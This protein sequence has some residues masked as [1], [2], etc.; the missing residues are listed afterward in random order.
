M[1][2]NYDFANLT[3]R[4]F[5]SLPEVGNKWIVPADTTL[6]INLSDNVIENVQKAIEA[7]GIRYYHLP[8]EERP[9]MSI[10]PLLQAVRLLK[11]QDALGGHMIVHCLFGNNRSRTV[12]D[13]FY[14]VKMGVHRPPMD[15]DDVNRLIF[16]CEQGYL[17]SL[18]EMEG[19]LLNL[20]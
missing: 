13:A 15:E 17:P 2:I 5:L 19:L 9:H 11:E 8:M 20:K 12:A 14:F 4:Q 6:I 16:N 18:A 3:T 10:E 1:I 7:K